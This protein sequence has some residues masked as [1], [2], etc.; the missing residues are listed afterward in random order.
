MRQHKFWPVRGGFYLVWA[1]AT[2]AF[3]GIAVTG[4]TSQAAVAASHPANASRLSS[5]SERPLEPAQFLAQ[6][7][8][9][10]FGEPDESFGESEEFF[11]EPEVQEDTEA[12]QL[13]LQQDQ[14]RLRFQQEKLQLEAENVELQQNQLQ[15]RR[16][17]INQENQQLGL[18][19]NSRA[20]PIE[21]A[22]SRFDESL[23]IV[24]IE[25]KILV[26]QS[27]GE[28][29]KT[30]ARELIDVSTAPG[31]YGIS[32]IVIYEP[33]E[34]AN[35]NSYRLYNSLRKGLVA[36]YEAEGIVLKQ[37][38]A[39]TP[40]G[41]RGGL[42]T[43]GVLQTSTTVLR[44]AA[45]I[46]SYFRSEEVLYPNAFKP[47]GNGFL[48]AQLVS[49]LRREKS[50]IQI[51]A[52]AVYLNS[53]SSSGN[54]VETFL[55]NLDQLASLRA[56]ANQMMSQSIDAQQI[57]TLQDLNAQADQ[58]LNLLRFAE[59]DGGPAGSGQGRAQI[60][61]LIQ[62]AQISQLLNSEDKR[63]LVLD[64]LESGGTSRTRRSLFSTMFTGQKTGYSGSAAVQYFLVNPD[65]SLAAA[66]VIYR[67]SGFKSMKRARSN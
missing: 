40:D 7:D 52:P 23:S 45:E 20:I 61:Q 19:E 55:S 51:Y 38:A 63:V 48:I 17:I 35:V 31:S 8:D 59:D 25:S 57:Q 21:Q 60:F 53:F 26:F 34:F 29:A 32:A 16:D 18:T 30:I 54:P 12:A 4:P 14:E 3:V 50:P 66:D 47:D 22:G 24:P 6:F 10:F 13:R 41:V 28:I 11:D 36:A 56:K 27:S 15:L 39:P 62:G 33:E 2:Q 5:Q 43:S 67:S 42:D 44:S 58:L 37:Q 9:E 46:L 64:L 65:N 49:A 1:I